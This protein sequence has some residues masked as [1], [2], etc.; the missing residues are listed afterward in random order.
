VLLCYP[1]LYQILGIKKLTPS[2]PPE[3][4]EIQL[5]ATMSC[6]FIINSAS[7]FIIY[8]LDIVHKQF[9]HANFYKYINST[10]ESI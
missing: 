7:D 1:G 2:P 4:L 5:H 10:E 8:E 9:T 3:W 6:S